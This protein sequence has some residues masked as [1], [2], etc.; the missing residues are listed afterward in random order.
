MIDRRRHNRIVISGSAVLT[1][2]KGGKPQSIQTLIAN[3]SSHGIGLYSYS[4]IKVSTPVSLV[5]HFISLDGRVKTDSIQGRIVS[6]RKIGKT[7]F[8]GI[9][10][11]EEIDAQNQPSLFEHLLQAIP[12]T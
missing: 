10:F 12:K 9:Q 2:I 5:V 11:D 3:I 4:S 8:L 1:V 7:H 6:N